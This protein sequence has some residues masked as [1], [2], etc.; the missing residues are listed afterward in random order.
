MHLNAQ[1]RRQVECCN[2]SKAGNQV[3]AGYMYSQ[4]SEAKIGDRKF[5]VRL[6]SIANTEHSVLE[7]DP[8]QALMRA[9]RATE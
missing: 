7:Q 9:C 4:P 3:T 8:S 1:L 2:E 6:D 5:R